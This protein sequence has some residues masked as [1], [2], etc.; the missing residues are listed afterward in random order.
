[1]HVDSTYKIHCTAAILDDPD[2]PSCLDF[3]NKLRDALDS[4]LTKNSASCAGRSLKFDQCPR[5]FHN[6][7]VHYNL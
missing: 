2:V 7:S 3:I 4:V 1:M 5:R 6:Q